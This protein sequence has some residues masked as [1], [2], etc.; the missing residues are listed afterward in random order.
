M[1]SKLT[2]EEM[3]KVIQDYHGALGHCR[4]FDTELQRFQA[5][6]NKSLALMMEVAELVDSLPWKPWR[7]IEDQPYDLDNAKR[8]IVDI[9][10]FLV[11]ICEDLAIEPE[12]IEEKFFQ[13]FHNNQKRIASGY[14]KI[15]FDRKEVI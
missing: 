13:V 3:Y 6:R 9:I 5:I 4:V 2:F 12:D 1:T 14:N 11:G 15:D 8:E 7:E 10:F